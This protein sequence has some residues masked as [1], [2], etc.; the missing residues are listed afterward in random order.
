M[1]TLDNSVIYFTSKHK[2]KKLVSTGNI[3]AGSVQK[4]QQPGK[5]LFTLTKGENVF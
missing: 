3:S 4:Q 2:S 1:Y 5:D